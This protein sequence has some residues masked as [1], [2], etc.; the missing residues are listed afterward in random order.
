MSHRVARPPVHCLGHRPPVAAPS[1]GPCRRRLSPPSVLCK[2]SIC[3]TEMRAEIL[4][5]KVRKLSDLKL[6]PV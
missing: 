4:P 2:S 5:M 1:F 6:H 3:M